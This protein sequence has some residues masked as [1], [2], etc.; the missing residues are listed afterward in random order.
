MSICPCCGQRLEPLPR[1]VDATRQFVTNTGS[2]RLAPSQYLMFRLLFR[3]RGELVT[4]DGF[5][6][7]IYGDWRE[8]DP[9]WNIVDIHIKDIRERIAPTNYRIENVRG[10][11]WR[12]V[13]RRDEK[14]TL[15][16]QGRRQARG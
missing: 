8:V 13:E 3:A 7:L 4:R 6:Q 2:V 9:D 11:G 16:D 10:R 1:L 14:E 12:L 15:R 5:L